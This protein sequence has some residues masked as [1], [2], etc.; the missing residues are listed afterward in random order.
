MFVR[1]HAC[2]VQVR[3]TCE[4][5]ERAFEAAK[6]EPVSIA[7]GYEKTHRATGDETSGP[8]RGLDTCGSALALAGAC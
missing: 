4:D 2:A 8:S 3:I 7:E 1:L 5:L 6:R